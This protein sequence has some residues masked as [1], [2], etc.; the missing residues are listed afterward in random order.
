[1]ITKKC[2][3]ELREKNQKCRKGVG[4]DPGNGSHHLTS[5]CCLL[6][7]QEGTNCGLFKTSL[8]KQTNETQ[9]LNL[10]I[11]MF[12]LNSLESNKKKTFQSLNLKLSVSLF[13]C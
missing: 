8:N 4:G 7:K 13:V 2:Y 6:Q 5:A 9:Y 10:K 1:M 12:Y 3:L 11:Q